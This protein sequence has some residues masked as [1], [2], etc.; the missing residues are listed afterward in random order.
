MCDAAVFNGGHHHTLF[1]L[2]FCQRRKNWKP[3]RN[4]E[5]VGDVFHTDVDH[6]GDVST[7]EDIQI[8]HNE[9]SRVSPSSWSNQVDGKPL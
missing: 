8:Q 7:A 3:V 4:S 1:V 5:R 9:G 6:L 2:L